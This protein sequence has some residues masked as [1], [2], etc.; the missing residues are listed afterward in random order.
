MSSIM[1][2]DGVRVYDLLE[3]S[4]GED[5]IKEP[6]PINWYLD[7][8]EI[9]DASKTKYT[10]GF[11]GITLSDDGEYVRFTGD[12]A[13]TEGFFATFIDDGIKSGKYAVI[14]YRIPTTNP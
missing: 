14:K 4:S 7:P 9:V 12:S 3:E 5:E 11:S 6:D 1:M 8:R 2:L 13:K 10:Q